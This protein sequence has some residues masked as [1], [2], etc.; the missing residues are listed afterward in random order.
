MENTDVFTLEEH[1]NIEVEEKRVDGQENLVD[2]KEEE[3]NPPSLSLFL[4]S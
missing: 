2:E 3:K 1:S 4:L